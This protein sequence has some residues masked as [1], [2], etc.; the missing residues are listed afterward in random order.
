M[1]FQVTNLQTNSFRPRS[2]WI[3]L[4][5]GKQSRKNR[6]RSRF[7]SPREVD[8]FIS[9]MPSENGL[10][11]TGFPSLLEV[12]RFISLREK[13]E[14]QANRELPSPREVNRFISY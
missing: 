1:T 4:Y 2:G 6:I 10:T 13:Y 8:R 12:Y 9:E 7:P 14:A 11:I 3:G 5:H